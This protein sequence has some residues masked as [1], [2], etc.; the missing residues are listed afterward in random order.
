VSEVVGELFAGVLGIGL[1]LEA[2]G[3]RTAW[4]AEID[5][6][7]RRVIGARRPGV[8]IVGD[9]RMVDGGGERVTGLAGGFPCQPVSAAGKG[10]AQAD[11]RWLWPAFEDAILVCEPEWV[12]IE[13][14]PMLRRRGLVDVLRGLHRLG[15]SAAFDGV[16]AAAVGAPHLRDRLWIWAW[17]GEGGPVFG[18][19]GGMVGDFPVWAWPEKPPRAGLMDER[20]MVWATSPVAPVKTTRRDGWSYWDGVPLWPTPE[21]SDGSGGDDLATAVFRRERGPLNPD[22]V[23]WLMGFPVGWTDP[24]REHDGPWP[25]GEP[26]ALWPTP[27]A[28]AFNVGADPDRHLERVA[29]IKARGINGNGAGLTLGMAAQLEHPGWAN[30]PGPRVKRDVPRRKERLT[31]AGNAVVP[32]VVSYVAGR[33]L[34]ARARRAA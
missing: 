19:P 9:V 26:G 33:G 8:E 15:Y 24:E 29:A 14:V 23:D 7:A 5:P 30:E 3:V 21:A 25:W 6:F 1:G 22:W 12:L 27:D 20:G 34:A 18:E 2:H 11:P 17:R 13:N 10:L 28:A 16:P 31:C 32:A 4:A